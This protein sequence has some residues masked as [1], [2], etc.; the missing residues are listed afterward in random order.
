MPIVKCTYIYD[1]SQRSFEPANS[2]THADVLV[3]VNEDLS[4]SGSRIVT[5]IRT[6]DRKHFNWVLSENTSV[7]A[8][9]EI[10]DRFAKG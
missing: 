7:T 2:D 6:S 4:G 5:A 3:Y 1:T 10:A 8:L 9:A